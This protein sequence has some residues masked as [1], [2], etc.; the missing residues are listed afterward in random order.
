MA[1]AAPAPPAT[2]ALGETLGRCA[3]LGIEDLA[4]RFGVGAPDGQ[5]WISR[6]VL[7]DAALRLP[8]MELFGRVAQSRR[9]D[10]RGVWLLEAYAGALAAP[11]ILAALTESRMP[12]VAADAVRVRLAGDGEPADVRFRRPAMAVLP[13]DPAAGHDGVVLV[14]DRAALWAWF[15]GR[16]T[17]HLAP[18]VDAFSPVVHRSRRALWLCVCDSVGGYLEW[19]GDGIGRGEA[20]RSDAALVLGVDAPLLGTRRPEEVRWSGGTRVVSVRSGCCLS[21]RREGRAG[22]GC[23]SCPR[24]TPE[25]RVARMEESG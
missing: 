16:L 8:H 21:Y 4:T 24:T 14:R 9:A 6:D 3:A 13:G 19:L 17:A 18:V 10:V 2:S 11:A 12:D 25:E 7:L 23:F 22:C 20:A 1:T 5:G 15:R